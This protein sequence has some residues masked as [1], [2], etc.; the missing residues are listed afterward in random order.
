MDFCFPTVTPLNGVAIKSARVEMLENSGSY[1]VSESFLSH[2]VDF[3]GAGIDITAQHLVNIKNE[4]NQLKNSKDIYQKDLRNRDPLGDKFEGEA[5]AI[6]H[7]N[8][9]DLPIDILMSQDFWRYLALVPFFEITAWRHPTLGSHNFGLSEGRSFARCFPYRMFIRADISYR[10][11]QGKDYNLATAYSA[12]QDQWASHV[13]GQ[14]YAC[15][16]ELIDE[17][18]K[19]MRGLRNRKIK[20]AT[21]VDREI[22]K[23][24]KLA[25]SVLLLEYFEDSLSIA[26]ILEPI[27]RIS[28]SKIN[29]AKGIY[30]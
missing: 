18:L 14:S 15:Q 3:R 7:K 9:K 1:G 11:S 16:P 29:G 28:E 5:S 23:E 20:K 13:I 8:L 6:V 21:Q 27:V 22:A 19:S 12:G 25:R 2:H 4:L 24:L 30:D 26:K 17:M 10:F